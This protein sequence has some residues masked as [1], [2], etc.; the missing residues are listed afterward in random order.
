MLESIKEIINISLYFELFDIY[1]DN[2]YDSP[3]TTDF[4]IGGNDLSSE[5]NSFRVQ[6]KR[7]SGQSYCKDKTNIDIAINSLRIVAGI[8]DYYFDSNDYSNPVKININT[9]NVFYLTSSLSKYVAIKIRR[10][11][12]TDTTNPSPFASSSTKLQNPCQ[13]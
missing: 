8:S 6:I 7:W 12:V 10:N 4:I 5:F 1:V 9:N 3:S 2:N 11:D 13:Y